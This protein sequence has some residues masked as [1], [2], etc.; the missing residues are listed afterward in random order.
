MNKYQLE[1]QLFWIKFTNDLPEIKSFH[2]GV[3]KYTKKGFAYGTDTPGVQYINESKL[4]PSIKEA[5][6]EMCLRLMQLPM[7]TEASDD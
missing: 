4:F 1:Q 2:V 6:E 7:S 5:V 3:F